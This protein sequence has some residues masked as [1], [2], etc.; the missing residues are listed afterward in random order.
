MLKSI[1]S[2]H[3]VPEYN[4]WAYSQGLL[5][6]PSASREVKHGQID[7]FYVQENLDLESISSQNLMRKFK[8]PNAST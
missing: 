8:G 3:P 6:V 7:L 1:I 4:I 2:L 5:P